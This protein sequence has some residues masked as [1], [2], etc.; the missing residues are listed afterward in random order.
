M[1][2]HHREDLGRANDVATWL[3]TLIQAGVYPAGSLLPRFRRLTPTLATHEVNVRAALRIL[4]ARGVVLCRPGAVARVESPLPFPTAAPPNPLEMTKS[5][6]S[7]L[8]WL[9]RLLVVAG[10]VE[11]LVP[12]DLWELFQR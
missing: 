10:I 2:T 4:H 3:T 6:R 11:R 8:I 9:G 7:H 5:L 1:T 12:D